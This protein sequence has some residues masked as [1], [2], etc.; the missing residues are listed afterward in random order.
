MVRI[1]M[2]EICVADTLPCAIQMSPKL[3][4]RK[5]L[6]SSFDFGRGSAPDPAG[7]AYSAPPD[8]L[9]G[10][11]GPT[12]KG[13]GRKGW[14]GGEEVEKGQGTGEMEGKGQGCQEKGVEGK[15]KRG[16]RRGGEKVRTP[17][18]LIPAYAPG[19]NTDLSIHC[20]LQADTTGQWVSNEQ[21]PTVPDP[22]EP[23]SHCLF[24]I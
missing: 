16:K 7:G 18:P 14:E 21:Q 20:C 1:P 13:S 23:A 24:S 2:S 4:R 15:G 17:P 6:E 12:S 22:Q 8:F 9:A 19:A 11:R 3:Q 5:L 10:F